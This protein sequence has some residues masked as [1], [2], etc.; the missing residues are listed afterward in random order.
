MRVTNRLACHRGESRKAT[1]SIGKSDKLS[2]KATFLARKATPSRSK[3]TQT[4]F[5]AQDT[6]N[7]VNLL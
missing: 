3:V 4:A 6:V 2:A 7:C 5:F 1:L